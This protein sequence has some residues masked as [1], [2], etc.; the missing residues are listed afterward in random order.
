M[1]V[2]VVGLRERCR[3]VRVLRF[4]ARGL[5][6]RS[7]LHATV[8][9]PVPSWTPAERRAYPRSG[10]RVPDTDEIDSTVLRYSSPL[11][12]RIHAGPKGPGPGDTSSWRGAAGIRSRPARRINTVTK[13]ALLS[14]MGFSSCYTCVTWAEDRATVGTDPSAAPGLEEEWGRAAWFAL[15]LFL[16][17]AF[18]FELSATNPSG[19][20]GTPPG[21]HGL[22]SSVLRC[23]SFKSL[24]FLVLLQ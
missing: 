13:V 6:G 21:K 9:L 17:M 8:P 22:P 24:E 2:C 18:L 1:V 12:N 3:L 14:P 5:W 19:A 10:V 16:P 15:V 23:R 20:R 7:F 4:C 11:H